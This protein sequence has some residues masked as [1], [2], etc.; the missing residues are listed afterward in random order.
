[1]IPVSLPTRAA[2]LSAQETQNVQ[3]LMDLKYGSGELANKIQE[4][5]A[6]DTSFI[7]EIESLEKSNPKGLAELESLEKEV[8]SLGEEL[9]KQEQML[10]R[11]STVA[12]FVENIL[13][14]TTA[15]AGLEG[16]K[17]LVV[18]LGSLTLPVKK[19]SGLISGQLGAEGTGD[20]ADT[21]PDPTP[22]DRELKI[23]AQTIQALKADL[24]KISE[25][26][27][28]TSYILDMWSGP[29]A[30]LEK[31][32]AMA[33]KQ[34]ISNFESNVDN[35]NALLREQFMILNKKQRLE[36]RKTDLQNRIRSIDLLPTAL[37]AANVFIDYTLYYTGTG[38]SAASK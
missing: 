14:I 37:K 27:P 11:L 33:A 21:V 4:V 29:K 2:V 36:A 9:S 6:E 13:P 1:M 32:S 22:I 35:S 28:W 38:A 19:I 8:T 25:S 20:N 23:N 3:R 10:K 12:S 17:L 16:S 26:R 15:L 7:K 24:D 18:A 5:F 31:E 30:N 34:L